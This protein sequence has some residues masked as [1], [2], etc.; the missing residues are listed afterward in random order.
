MKTGLMIT[1]IIFITAQIGA[2]QPVITPDG[3]KVVLLNNGTWRYAEVS[4]LE[5][6]QNLN[7]APQLAAKA[8]SDRKNEIKSGIVSVDKNQ[9]SLIDIVKNDNNYDFRTIRWGMNKAQ[10]AKSETAKLLKNDGE[11]VNYE[12]EFLGYT[13]QVVYVFQKDRL[14]RAELKILQDH[15][16]PARYFKDYEDLKKYLQQIYGASVSDK[17]EWKNEM[18]SGDPSKWGFAVSIGF[19]SCRTVWKD[20]RTIVSLNISGGN[21]QITTIIEY[22]EA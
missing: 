11:N 6:F 9:L 10:V 17:N 14:I 15:V 16:D 5:L 3:K 2:D 4:D 12:L 13:C 7:K 19:L 8:S 18:Y 21:H 22:R 20:S 1:V